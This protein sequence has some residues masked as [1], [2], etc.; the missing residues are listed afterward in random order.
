M[1][2]AAQM[3]LAENGGQNIIPTLEQAGMQQ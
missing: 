2:Q 3:D 1:G